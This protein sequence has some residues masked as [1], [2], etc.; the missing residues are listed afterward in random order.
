MFNVIKVIFV[1]YTVILVA[2]SGFLLYFRNNEDYAAMSDKFKAALTA[3]VFIWFG[4]LFALI[5][6]H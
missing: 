4:F 3:L 6:F 2:V 5:E 1:I